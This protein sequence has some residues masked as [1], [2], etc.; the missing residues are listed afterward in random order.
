MKKIFLALIAGLISAG[1]SGSFDTANMGPDDRLKHAQQLYNDEDY[2]E[3]V[4]EFQN[5]ILQFPGNAV[6]DDAQYYLG[7]TRFKRSEFILSAFEFSK[8]IKNMPASEFVSDAQ[9][10]LAESYYELSPSFN[11]DQTYT[12][13]AIEEYQAFI[14]F[15]PANTRVPEAEQKINELNDKLAQK[16]FNNAVIYEKMEYYTA[17]LMYYTNVVE[18]YHDTRY[19]P[20]ALYN[21][22]QILINRERNSEAITEIDKFLQRYPDNTYA[23]E[24]Q[25]LK[26]SI[27]NKLSASK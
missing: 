25:K 12:K 17:A 16:E 6:V 18:T 19:A 23:G 2:Q 4:G 10:M 27:E 24:L 20:R 11:L 15:F 13:K 22:I 1:C 9:Y 3:A 21:K 8:L 14:D 26:L 5:I 7:L